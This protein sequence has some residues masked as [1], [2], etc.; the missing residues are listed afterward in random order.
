MLVEP[1][2]KCTVNLVKDIPAHTKYIYINSEM[3]CQR[4][5]RSRNFFLFKFE[6]EKILL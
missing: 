6:K 5:S 4:N 1:P 3:K 2:T